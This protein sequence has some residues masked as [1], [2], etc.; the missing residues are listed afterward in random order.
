MPPG[1]VSRFMAGW[2]RAHPDWRHEM[3]DAHGAADIVKAVAGGEV[4][5]AFWRCR[6]PGMRA[7]IFRY[8]ALYGFGG[9][10]VDAH[11]R[12]DRPL[13]RE[14]RRA[15]RGLMLDR[16]GKLATDVMAFRAPGDP[17]L[18]FA[19]DSVLR[20]V[21]LKVSENPWLVTGPGVFAKLY[22]AHQNA[23]ESLLEGLTIIDVDRLK[24][25]IRVFW[26]VANGPAV[27][28]ASPP[29]SIF[30]TPKATSRSLP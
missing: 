17:L 14:W 4:A 12:C 19:L 15:K 30:H 2:D 18:G 27:P 3:F 25:A 6:L 10:Y 20:N 8:A 13:A 21:R 7:D 16:R 5:Q 24:T 22:A 26:D 11:I 23:P 29:R 1:E 9:A 28:A